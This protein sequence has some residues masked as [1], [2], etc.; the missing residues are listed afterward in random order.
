M[1]QGEGNRV[2]SFRNDE[3][4]RIYCLFLIPGNPTS[5][6]DD[7]HI[8]SA[9]RPDGIYSPEFLFPIET[10]AVLRVKRT[11]IVAGVC[12]M[13]EITSPLND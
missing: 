10:L 9:G 4:A 1:E 7:N 6:Y 8:L 11:G 2:R 5:Q 3:N 13:R 12:A